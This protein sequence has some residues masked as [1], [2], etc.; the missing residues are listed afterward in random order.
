MP[1]HVCVIEK[2]VAAARRLLLDDPTLTVE[3]IAAKVGFSN[4][5]H[6]ALAFRRHTGSSPAVF[7]RLHSR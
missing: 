6:L 1:V 4:S 2:R 5:S 7:R 3:S